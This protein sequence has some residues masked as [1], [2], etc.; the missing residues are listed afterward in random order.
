MFK[1]P[2]DLLPVLLL[3]LLPARL[4]ALQTTQPTTQPTVTTQ[5]TATKHPFLWRIESKGDQTFAVKSWLYG[6]MHTGDKRL[7]TLPDSVKHAWQSADAVYCEVKLDRSQKQR[8]QTA[9]RMLL[10]GGQTLRDRLPRYLYQRVS[11]YVRDHG[12]SMRAFDRMQVWAV[13]MYLDQIDSI[14][15][16]MT[17]HLD[18]MLY[19]DAKAAGKEVGGLET[20][21]EQL[22]VQADIPEKDHIE[23]LSH[24]LDYKEK[25]AAKGV[26]P[27]RRLLEAYLAGDEARILAQLQEAHGKNK[28]LGERF[29]KP[30]VERDVRMA[31]RMARM[32]TK[33]PRKSYFFAVGALHCFGK[34]S[35]AEL[36][37]RRGYRITRID[38]P[39][40]AKVDSRPTS[41]DTKP[42]RKRFRVVR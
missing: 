27:T 39:R 21:D 37:R 24:S 33:H 36:L 12:F 9:R 3:A 10:P 11:D 1:V 26:S 8:E 30:S 17:Y 15:A 38:P 23:L 14:R 18:L 20:K 32:M 22:G 19:L 40:K 25:L 31:D 29:L 41:Q 5:P 16:K 42:T 28:E 7:V 2:R 6:T 4:P 34:D 13:S 35:V